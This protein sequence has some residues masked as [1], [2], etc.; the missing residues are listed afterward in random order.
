MKNKKGF[1]LA[2]PNIDSKLLVQ[3][4]VNY[5]DNPPIFSLEQVQAGSYCF[6]ALEQKLKAD[7]AESVF[8]RRKLSWQ[9]IKNQGKHA[10]GFEKIPRHQIK[11]PI[12]N[13]ITNDLDFFLAFRFSGKC[14]M[15]GYRKKDV[16][17]VLW[18]DHN[19][20]AYPHG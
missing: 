17:Y 2:K 4:P 5:D 20:S 6:S 15:L 13:F 7:F 11:P 8:E 9:D 18:F 12:P 16:F 3:E 19:F 10:L 1:K 14:P